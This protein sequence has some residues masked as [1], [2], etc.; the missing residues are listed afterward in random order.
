MI[1]KILT[2]IGA[3]MHKNTT[4]QRLQFRFGR[5]LH[6]IVFFSEARV[7]VSEKRF[8]ISNMNMKKMNMSQSR[9]SKNDAQI[10]EWSLERGI[11]LGLEF[12]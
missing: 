10:E 12:S 1:A 9:A 7:H 2:S 11:L 5:L 6:F 8:Y 3:Q 4:I